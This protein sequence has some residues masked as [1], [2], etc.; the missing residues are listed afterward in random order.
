M[1]GMALVFRGLHVEDP[2]RAP[3][4]DEASLLKP[5]RT[6]DSGNL[7]LLSFR[8]VILDKKLLLNMK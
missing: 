3:I 5:G 4:T 1:V 6:L 7:T 2:L 8:S